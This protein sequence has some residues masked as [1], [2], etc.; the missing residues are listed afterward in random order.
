MD[1]KILL[2][3]QVKYDLTPQETAMLLQYLGVT[4]R[5]A[6]KAESPDKRPPE[7]KDDGKGT[8]PTDKAEAADKTA[9]EKKE[10]SPAERK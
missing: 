9:P 10:N 3:L 5:S 4:R 2:A 6:D 7:K 8:T 1:S